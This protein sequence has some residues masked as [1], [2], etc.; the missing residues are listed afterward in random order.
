MMFVVLNLSRYS[1]M[2]GQY[3]TLHTWNPLQ[4]HQRRK[5]RKLR[6][7]SSAYVCTY[8]FHLWSSTVL[9]EG[10]KAHPLEF[11]QMSLRP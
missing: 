10:F 6:A 4:S 5:K 3:Q 9:C 7:D 1:C 11:S 8:V 2:Q